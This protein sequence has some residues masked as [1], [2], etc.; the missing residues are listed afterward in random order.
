MVPGVPGGERGYR[1]AGSGL[2]TAARARPPVRCVRGPGPRAAFEARWYEGPVARPAGP[3]RKWNPSRRLCLPDATRQDRRTLSAKLAAARSALS[4][5]PPEER[6]Q[7]RREISR[8]ELRPE[9]P[10]GV[11]FTQRNTPAA[12]LAC[13]RRECGYHTKRQ[14]RRGGRQG[15]SSRNAD[16]N[17]GLP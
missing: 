12:P 3:V 11:A 6:I 4:C 1:D 16:D 8:A 9:A 5:H 15:L 10:L 13:R 17:D 14:Q 2:A 7:P